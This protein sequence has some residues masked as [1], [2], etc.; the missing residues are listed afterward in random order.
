MLWEDPRAQRFFASLAAFARVL[1]FDKRG[2]GVSDPIPTRSSMSIAPTLELASEDAAAV[3]DAEKWR[4]ACLVGIGCGCWVAALIAAS[5]PER[6]SHLV[7]VDAIPGLAADPE[8][9][10]GPSR[11]DA[12]HFVKWIIAAH[13]TGHVLRASDPTAY[14]DPEFRRW[15][16]R[17]QRFAMPHKWMEAFWTSV[18]ELQIGSVLSSITA[19]TLVMN[20]ARSAIWPVARGRALAER[21]PGAEFRE[22]PGSDELFFMSHPSPLLAELH[23][24]LSGERA[25]PIVDRVLATILFTDIARRN[26]SRP[27][28]TTRGASCCCGTTTSCGAS[29]SASAGARSIARAMVS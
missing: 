11:E 4:R 10:I 14:R 2:T 18:G 5:A 6:V 24:F 17:L 21:I 7:L 3:L 9:P 8:F 27:W 25:A 19:P 22:L 20:R 26:G 13:G 29:S 16:G 1:Q 12:A 23:E 15:Y 28:E